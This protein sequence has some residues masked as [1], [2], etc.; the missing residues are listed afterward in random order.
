M[1][2]N[3]ALFSILGTTSGGDGS[4]T[5]GLPD[6]RGRV[7]LY[8]GAGPGLTPRVPGELAG[9]SQVTLLEANLPAHAHD[10]VEIGRA[11]V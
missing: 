5:F 7:P 3:A 4:L 2:Q 9:V 8:V 10:L 6:F 11:H 1:A